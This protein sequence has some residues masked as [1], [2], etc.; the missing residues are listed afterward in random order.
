MAKKRQPVGLLITD[1]HLKDGNEDLVLSI[2][3]QAIKIC[4]AHGLSTIYHLGDWF[5]S[6]KSQSL[7]VLLTTVRIKNAIEEAGLIL[8][9]IPGNHDKTDLNSDHSFLDFFYDYKCFRVID[10]FHRSKITDKIKVLW[11]PYYKVD[12]WKEKLDEKIKEGLDKDFKW[13]LFGHQAVNGAVNNDGSKVKNN[14]TKN[15]FKDFDATFFGHYHNQSGPYLGSAYQSNFGEDT[16][17][18][19][20]LL[21]SDLSTEHIQLEFPAYV[22]YVADPT[23]E[24]QFKSITKKVLDFKL[25]NKQHVVRIELT[26]DRDKI[27]SL[28]KSL[29]AEAGVQVT[30]KF[31]DA[32]VSM[33]YEEGEFK[34]FDNET[35]IQ[36]FSEFAEEEKLDVEQGI[37]FIEKAVK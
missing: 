20:T 11:C 13:V 27:I 18:G 16:N 3:Q 28:D 1:T 22:K 17:K 7:S 8:E 37:G 5:T 30:S 34:V 33:D 12:L 25:K 29:F 14:L 6:R 32:K 31:D 24:K 10:C 4:Q 21:Y 9:V 35:I 23:N 2:F 15:V 36:E 26:G 19:V